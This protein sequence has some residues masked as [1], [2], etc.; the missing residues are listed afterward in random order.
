MLTPNTNCINHGDQTSDLFVVVSFSISALNV[1]SMLFDLSLSSDKLA[2]ITKK[3]KK[4]REHMWR[5]DERT[6][7]EWNK[8]YLDNRVFRTNA[9]QE[10]LNN[11]WRTYF[12]KGRSRFGICF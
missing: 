10:M 2:W 3:G 9:N 11:E 6:V 4:V 7:E 8:S 5:K 12:F 1:A